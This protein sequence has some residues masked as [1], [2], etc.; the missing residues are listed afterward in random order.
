M[1]IDDSE[2]SMYVTPALSTVRIP[3]YDEG[4]KAAEELFSLIENEEK[5]TEKLTY[6]PHKIIRRFSVK[7]I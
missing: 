5:T 1:G 2:V 3:Y 6:V 7:K 4:K